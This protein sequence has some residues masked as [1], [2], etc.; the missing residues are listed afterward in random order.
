M[1]KR[2]NMIFTA[3]DFGIS[4][5]AN[6]RI[7]RLAEGGAL[8]RVAIMT[9]GS[10]TKESLERLAQSGVKLDL[11]AELRDDIDPNRTLKA[12]VL[13]RTLVFLK[14]VLFGG[15]RPSL[16]KERWESQIKAFHSMFGKFPDGFNSHEHTH[17]FPPYFRS[18]LKLT[19]KYEIDF[20]RFGKESFRGN[21]PVSLI[22]NMLRVFD[23]RKFRGSRIRSTDFLVSFDW[24][25]DLKSLEKYPQDKTIEI[26]FHPERD[27]EM[28]FLER[29]FVKSSSE[30]RS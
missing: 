25:G 3:D 16:V 7:L 27:E 11:H 29:N 17:F 13:G 1:K 2:S 15:N 12:G 14:S 30:R 21:A 26:I 22:L 24:V 28:D 20:I 5:K 23:R 4:S 18:A 10:A 6:D 19:E 9:H 8:N